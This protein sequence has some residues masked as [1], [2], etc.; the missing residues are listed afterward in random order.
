MIV[1]QR[2]VLYFLYVTLHLRVNFYNR[3]LV[4][5]NFKINVC[6][7]FYQSFSQHSLCRPRSSTSVVQWKRTCSDF[8]S[9]LPDPD[10]RGPGCTALP[11]LL[12]LG[13]P[14]GCLGWKGA[15]DWKTNAL[16]WKRCSLLPEK[17]S[18]YNFLKKIQYE[19]RHLS[20]PSM[21]FKASEAIK[22]PKF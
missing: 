19:L 22:G 9:A 1:Y 10:Q 11:C 5:M 8:F 15:Q 4:H 13:W 16:Y 14:K 18:T 12:Q 17:V 3:R 21:G 20:R 6:F 7:S 2:G